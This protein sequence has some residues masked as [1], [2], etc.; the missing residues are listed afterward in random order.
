LNEFLGVIVN[1]V[2]IDRKEFKYPLSSI[3]AHTIL[4][5]ANKI[6]FSNWA[7][8]KKSMDGQVQKLEVGQQ[9]DLL[10]SNLKGF[11]ILP[12]DMTEG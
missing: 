7:V 10:N 12:L 6:H 5:L 8:Y 4:K 2:R 1:K 3:T 11:V 9:V